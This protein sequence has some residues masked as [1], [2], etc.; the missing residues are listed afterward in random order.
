[1]D[2]TKL[3]TE[4]R[5]AVLK[6]SLLTERVRH[7]LSPVNA[8]T[9]ADASPVTLADLGAQALILHHLRQYFPDLPAVAEEDD[10]ALTAQPPLAEALIHHLKT[11]DS[12]LDA[13]SILESLNLGR[14]PG[15]SEGAFWTLDP[16]DGTRGFLRG[17]QYALALAL[18]ECGAPVL[19]VLGCPAFPTLPGA[20]STGVLFSARRGHGAFSQTIGEPGSENPVRVSSTLDASRAVFCESLEPGHSHHGAAAAIAARLGTTCPP[21]RMDS[22][23]KYAAVARGEADIYLRLPTRAGYEE[24][25][26]DHAAGALLVEEAGGQVSDLDGQPLD[27]SHG[28]TLRANR[29]IVATNGHLHE[30]VL[31]AVRQA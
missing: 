24:T 10:H 23:C 28:R 30:V 3:M 17:D 12:S 8:L 14:H 1:M 2:D 21:V 5:S 13:D 16:I 11:I 29:G 19:A 4:A 9:K 6:A 31:A 25:I 7:S 22:Q 27:F 20:T 26:W 15:G 18:I